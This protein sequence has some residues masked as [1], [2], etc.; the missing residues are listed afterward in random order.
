MNNEKQLNVSFYCTACLLCV[1][2]CAC[3]CHLNSLMNVCLN[4]CLCGPSGFTLQSSSCLFTSRML[5]RSYEAA[6]YKRLSEWDYTQ[7]LKVVT[8]L[9]NATSCTLAVIHIWWLSNPTISIV[10][11]IYLSTRVNIQ[12]FFFCNS[13]WPYTWLES[14][15][16]L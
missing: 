3:Q 7:I 4:K 11:G 15:L 2:A 10:S 1:S 12:W 5:A 9:R 8:Y 6:W 16:F 13:V 14:F